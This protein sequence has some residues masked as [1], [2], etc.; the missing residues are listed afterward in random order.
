MNNSLKTRQVVIG[1]SQSL[2]IALL[3]LSCCAL[4]EQTEEHRG[5]EYCSGPRRLG[6]WFRLERRF[7]DILV[8]MLQRQHRPRAE[9]SF[10]EYVAA[11]KRILAQPR[12]TV[13]SCRS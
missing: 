11:T 10:K 4:A 12:W 8:K 6:R 13:H 9:T 1:M 7:Y 3:L 2:C 5:S